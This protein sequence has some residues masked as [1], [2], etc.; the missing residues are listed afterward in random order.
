[1][2][3]SLST[4]V[5]ENRYAVR[6]VMLLNDLHK[7]FPGRGFEHYKLPQPLEKGDIMASMMARNKVFK[8]EN[9]M[10]NNNR[11]RYSL[12]T[13]MPVVEKEPEKNQLFREI[14]AAGAKEL[15]EEVMEAKGLA[16]LNEAKTDPFTSLKH[17]LLL[18]CALTENFVERGSAKLKGLVLCV[19]DEKPENRY[20]IV[21]RCYSKNG[22]KEYYLWIDS[23]YCKGGNAHLAMD[24]NSTW[25]NMVGVNMSGM[26]RGYLVR[27][28]RSWTA[29][30][31]LLE[32]E[33]KRYM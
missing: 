9:F 21:G 5:Q 14:A 26:S 7:V 4:R 12:G 31:A 17:H 10:E 32:K 25:N 16:T 33:K 29:G 2:S 30:L 18:A 1:M 27:A 15:H 24:F 19:D 20:K 23:R 22:K 6:T 3:I 28:V 11:I 13:R 8:R